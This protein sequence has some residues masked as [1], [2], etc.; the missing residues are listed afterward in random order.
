[1]PTVSSRGLFFLNVASG[2]QTQVGRLPRLALP[3]PY[4]PS[5]REVCVVGLE[6]GGWWLLGERGMK[7]KG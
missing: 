2:D 6:E 7:D 4:L 3:P 1:M 5:P